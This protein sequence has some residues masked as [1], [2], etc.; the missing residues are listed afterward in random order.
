MDKI[1]R[2]EGGYLLTNSWLVPTPTGQH[3]MIDAPI[4]ALQWLDSLEITPA[5]LLLTHQ[6]FDHVMTAAAIANRGVPIFS[7][8]DFSRQLTAEDI[9]RQWGMP[10]EVPAFTVDHIL[11]AKSQVTIA[12]L[13]LYLKHVPG[14]SADSMTFYDPVAGNLFA[15]DTLFNG[16]VGRGDLPGGDLELLCK[17]ILTKLYTYPDATVVYPGHG[18]TTEIGAE[19]RSN[20][21]VR[22]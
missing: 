5:A 10:M 1:L 19:K 8:S 21:V 16:S 22:A 14:H 18:P 7:W 3:L 15:G 4:D 17:G 6:H 9:V 20:A 12:G 13:E 2:F 11:S